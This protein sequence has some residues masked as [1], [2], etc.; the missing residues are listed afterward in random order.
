MKEHP[1][2][3]LWIIF[4]LFSVVIVSCGSPAKA[5]LPGNTDLINIPAPSLANNVLGDS[6]QQEIAVYLPPSYQESNQKY[7]VVY[8]LTGASVKLNAPNGYMAVQDGMNHLL[9]L[10]K[11]QEMIIVTVSGFNIL[12]A[13]FYVNSPVTGNWQDFILKDVVGYVDQHYRTLAVSASRGITGHSMGGAA[14]LNMAMQHPDIFGS[15]YGLSP[16]LFDQNGLSD[17]IMFSSQTTI[18][19]VLDQI[20]SLSK[21]PSDQRAKEFLKQYYHSNQAVQ[22]TFAY[23]AA[24]S[25]AADPKPPYIF[26]PYQRVNDQ[27]VRDETVWKQ[28][29]SGF[30]E[31]SDKVQRYKAN[32]L[33][34]HGIALDYGQQD[35]NGWI[36]RG[37][38]LFSQQLNSAGITNT[39]LTFNGTHFDHLAQRIEESMLPFFSK[40]LVFA[41]K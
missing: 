32:L 21:L 15:V 28:W 1:A 24:I 19:M 25:P 3:V 18:N 38:Q 36:P 39:L 4:G 12:G 40:E 23:G 17:S 41:N 14:A 22:F 9:A 34:L 10:G 37:C 20:E 11:I 35:E 31:I 5:N 30:G 33:R 26:Y 13:S 16:A 7:P 6:T 8:Y 29:D 27:V 2:S